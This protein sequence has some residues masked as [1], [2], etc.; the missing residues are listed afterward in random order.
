M[1]EIYEIKFAGCKKPPLT[2]IPLQHLGVRGNGP[3]YGAKAR[4]LAASVVL[5]K[6]QI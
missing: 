5:L 1:V 6:E 3:V 4:A 2:I